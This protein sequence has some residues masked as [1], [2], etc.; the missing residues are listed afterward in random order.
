[1]L[2]IRKATLPVLAI[3]LSMNNATAGNKDVT[4]SPPYIMRASLFEELT[5]H[6]DVV[7]FGDSLTAR[8]EWHEFFNGVSLANRGIGGD[9]TVGMLSR[10][11]PI[12]AMKPKVVFIMAGVNDVAARRTAPEIVQA[13]QQIVNKFAEQGA[14]VVVQSTLYVSRRTRLSHNAVISDINADMAS[15]CSTSKHCKF[16]DLNASMSPAGRLARSYTGDGVHLNGKGYMTWMKAIHP[17]IAQFSSNK[18]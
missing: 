15:F 8:G 2:L 12:L 5:E 6:R 17:A 9:T 16:I 10:I 1:M 14:E 11:A 4:Q 13:Y 3:I 18:E 7:M